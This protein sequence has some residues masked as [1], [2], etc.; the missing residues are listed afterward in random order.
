[1]VPSAEA[2]KSLRLGCHSTGHSTGHSTAASDHDPVAA[3][4]GLSHGLSHN[5]QPLTSAPPSGA[6]RAA[7]AVQPDLIQSQQHDYSTRELFEH[8]QQQQQLP[9]RPGQPSCVMYVL[10]GVCATGAACPNDHPPLGR[11]GK[12]ATVGCL[13]PGQWPSNGSDT[14]LLQDTSLWQ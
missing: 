2:Y 1:V 12:F 11:L 6:A 4:H 14:H 5:S 9:R 7:A 10:R 3:T 13:L 8:H